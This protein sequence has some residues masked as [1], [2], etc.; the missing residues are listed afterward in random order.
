MEVKNKEDLIDSAIEQIK[1]DINDGDYTALAELLG[2][3]PEKH[4]Q[5]FLSDTGVID[6]ADETKNEALAKPES[7]NYLVTL[8]RTYDAYKEI[9][10]TVLAYSEDD[11]IKKAF[12]KEYYGEYKF[13]DAELKL[14]LSQ[15]DEVVMVLE[16]IKE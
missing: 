15:D 13:D 16:E 4:L 9:T 5:G 1:D 6:V 7:K 3:L 12:D 14:D 8:G 10:H 11:A 2:L